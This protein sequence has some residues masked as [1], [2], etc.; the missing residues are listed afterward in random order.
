MSVAPFSVTCSLR[1]SLCLSTMMSLSALEN[2][3]PETRTTKSKSRIGTIIYNKIV[4]N[5]AY[6]QT[7]KV[8]VIGTSVSSPQNRLLAYPPAARKGVTR[9]HMYDVI[10]VWPL[11]FVNRRFWHHFVLLPEAIT[12]IM[13]QWWCKVLG[14]DSMLILYNVLQQ[15][16]QS[17]H[18]WN[19]WIY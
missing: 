2:M 7:H 5:R 18:L 8:K 4:D 11:S 3:S 13:L 12:F 19:W 14:R 6:I 16:S 9:K 10:V 17:D 15:N 1:T